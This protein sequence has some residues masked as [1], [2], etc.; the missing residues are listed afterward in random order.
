MLI[1]VPYDVFPI[2]LVPHIYNPFVQLVLVA[3]T[4]NT[5][6]RFKMSL[7]NK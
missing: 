7:F 6:Y 3:P 5:D 1:L 4:E 2:K